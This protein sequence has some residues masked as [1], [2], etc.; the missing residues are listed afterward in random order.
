MPIEHHVD[1]AYRAYVVTVYGTFSQEDVLHSVNA[2]YADQEYKPGMYILL[3][4]TDA[5]GKSLTRHP[6]EEYRALADA[7]RARH[8]DDNVL[9]VVAPS[10][11]AYGLARMNQNWFADTREVHVFR[12]LTEAHSH[13]R[14]EA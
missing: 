2:R 6:D 1:S 8:Q 12:S 11:I 4:L 9:L 14:G 3:D 5:D 13:I 7:S 10:D